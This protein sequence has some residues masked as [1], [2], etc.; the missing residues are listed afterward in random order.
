MKRKED[1]FMLFGE[2]FSQG[3]HLEGDVVLNIDIKVRE[4][5]IIGHGVGRRVWPG[6]TLRNGSLWI[7]Y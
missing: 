4:E 5:K 1:K 3:L 6:R 7:I 2:V